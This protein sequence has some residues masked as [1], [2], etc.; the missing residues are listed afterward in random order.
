[1]ERIICLDAFH[2]VPNPAEVLSELGRV[3]QQGGVAGFAE[4]G[5]EYSKTPQSQFEMRTHGVVEN[6]IDITGSGP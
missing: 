4:P 3:L 5:P 2:H 6:D 1:M